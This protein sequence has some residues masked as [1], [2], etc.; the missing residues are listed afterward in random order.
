MDAIRD[1]PKIYMYAFGFIAEF[2]ALALFIYFVQDGY[3]TGLKSKYISLDPSSGNC[4]EVVKS[5]SGVYSADENGTWVGHPGYSYSRSLYALNLVDASVLQSDYE[6]IMLLAKQEVTNLG[7]ASQDF[8]LSLNLII[9]MSWMLIC[10]PTL[11]DFCDSFDGQTFSFTSDAQYMLALSHIDS[12]ISNEMGDCL[13][14]SVSEY[15]LSNAL[16]KG[17][18]NV[19]DFLADPTCNTAANPVALGYDSYLDGDILNFEYDVRSLVNSI[20]VNFNLVFLD[21]LE[22]VDYSPEYQFSHR[23]S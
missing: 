13:T 6:N 14:Y 3:F 16:N 21:G 23:V 17:T 8:D 1:L 2:G 20:A 18:Y 19:A 10:D 4:V 11:Y 7:N 22:H 9:Y 5:V 15:D 12:T